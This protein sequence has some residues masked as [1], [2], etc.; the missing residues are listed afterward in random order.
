LTARFLANENFPRPSIILAREAG[1]EVLSVA[2]LMPG[3]TDRAVLEFA[4]QEGLWV[5]TLDRD[6]GELVFAGKV[7]C[8]PAILYFRQGTYAPTWPGERLRELAAVP[9]TVLGHL[10][11]VT[12]GATRRRPLPLPGSPKS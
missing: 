9:D 4:V 8:P 3:A 6:Y 12:E 1:L 11:V 7:A 2:D 10:V 5:V